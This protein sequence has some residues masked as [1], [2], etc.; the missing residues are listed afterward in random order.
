[1]NIM[2]NNVSNRSSKFFRENFE[3]IIVFVILLFF[4]IAK[5]S[6][7]SVITAPG[8]FFDELIYITTTRNIFYFSKLQYAVYPP[9]YS[10]IL[11][12]ALFFQE[13]W[14]QALLVINCV[15]TSLTLLLIW[16]IVRKHVPP[17]VSILAILIAAFTPYQAIMPTYLLAE[18]L[19]TLI[20]L[21]LI[22]LNYFSFR[23]FKSNFL[24]GSV[25]ALLL[26]TKYLFLP[27]IPVMFLLNFIREYRSKN[28]LRQLVLNS[29]IY[30]IGFIVTFMPWI[31]YVV[32]SGNSPLNAFGLEAVNKLSNSITISSLFV[33]SII[34][35]SYFFLSIAPY[36][37]FTF[38]SLLMIFN[39]KHFSVSTNLYLIAIVFISAIHIAVASHHSWSVDY[40]Y[41]IPQYI[42]G[43]Y[44]VHLPVL[45][46]IGT[47]LVVNDLTK[48]KLVF[49]KK[50]ALLFIISILASLL[51]TIMSNLVLFHNLL[52]NLPSWFADITFNSVDVINFGK[53]SLVRFLIPIICFTPITLFFSIKKRYSYFLIFYP[54]LIFNIYTYYLANQRISVDIVRNGAYSRTLSEFLMKDESTSI[55]VVVSPELYPIFNN[56]SYGISFWNNKGKT[57][58]VYKD[59]FKQDRETYYYL[60]SKIL[61]DDSIFSFSVGLKEYHVYS[62]K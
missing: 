5:I 32:L 27:I 29:Y 30:C 17:I 51:A 31:I 55:N 60:T 24:K 6:N 57:I 36:L 34:Y 50:N 4:T 45:F 39:K 42:I 33:W 54:I 2:I 59:E 46:L 53:Y 15:I 41:P 23:S 25:S 26:L 7:T 61:D 16:T 8:V 22:Y 47:F 56:L 9:L 11:S 44:L 38:L 10:L 18:N 19:S 43:R 3:V 35:F 21:L 40:N 48:S 62:N 28:G 14:Y 58:S 12:P 1:M 49:S 37:P 20:F 52:W 13:N